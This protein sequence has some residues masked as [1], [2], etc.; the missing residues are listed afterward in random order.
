MLLFT[1]Y[2]DVGRWPLAVGRWPLAVG[3]WTLDVGRWTLDVGRWTLDVGRWTLD[4]GRWTLDKEA[5]VFWV[6][7]S[8]GQSF[9]TQAVVNGDTVLPP[10]GAWIVDLVS[11]RYR[12][13]R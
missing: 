9:Q 5:I 4:V 12:M 2:L 10:N 1:A 3:R 8:I 6:K 7:S 11:F 13:G